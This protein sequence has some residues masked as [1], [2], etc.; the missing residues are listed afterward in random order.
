VFTL[1][2]IAL[3]CLAATAWLDITVRRRHEREL[4]TLASLP[5][6][7]C[8]HPLGRDAA[9]AARTAYAMGC[10]EARLRLPNCRINFARYWPV[11]CPVCHANSEFHFEKLNLEAQKS[12]SHSISPPLSSEPEAARPPL[13]NVEAV[14]QPNSKQVWGGEQKS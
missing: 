5:C 7:N 4:S 14:E 10:D 2:F 8:G 11:E 6:P 13:L 9:A 3:V 1:I 12:I